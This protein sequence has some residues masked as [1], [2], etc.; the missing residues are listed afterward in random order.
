[1]GEFWI[2]DY[3]ILSERFCSY[4]VICDLRIGCIERPIDYSY[5]NTF[6]EVAF[7]MNKVCSN[8]EYAFTGYIGRL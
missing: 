1:M 4:N 2:I 6:T 5:F 8:G 7:S 3:S